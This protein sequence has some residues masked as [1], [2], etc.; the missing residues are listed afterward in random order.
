MSQGYGVRRVQA[1]PADSAPPPPGDPTGPPPCPP[2]G[3]GRGRHGGQR[4]R[5]DRPPRREGGRADHEAAA[6]EAKAEEPAAKDETKLLM[7]VLGREDSPVKVYG[8]IQN[9]YTG[10]TNG[11]AQE[12]PELRRQPELPGQ[13][14]DGQPVLPDLR[15]PARAE[16]R[17]QLRLP[18]RQPVRQRLAVQP[19]AGA[20]RH[21]FQLNHFAGYDPAQIYAE[22]HLP[23]LTKGGIDI[24]GGRFYTIL[25]YEV[26]PATGRPLLSVPYMFNYGQPFTHF[27]VLSTLHL[28]DRSTS[29]TAR[30][31]ARTAGST[32]TTSGTTS[33]ASPGPPRRARPT[34][35]SPTSGARTS[36]PRYLPGTP[37]DRPAR[38]HDVPSDSPAGGNL[39]YGANNRIL[40]TNVFSYKWT[41]KLTQ[42]IETDEAFENNIPGS[43]GR[44]QR[45]VQ[46]GTTD[47]SW[48]SFG[49][50][51]LYSPV[52][53]QADRR[54][55]VGSLPRQQR[56]PHRV[57]RQL[58]RADARPDLQAQA[59]ALDPARSPVRLGRS[60]ATPYNDG[61]RKSQ[62][63]LAVDVI[64]LF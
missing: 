61:T 55:A 41:D 17:D 20:V 19:H 28:T 51:F 23:L 16:R 62:F 2:R 32:R 11:A 1:T 4:D 36:I 30:S 29:T 50:W 64:L 33:A 38:Q 37:A 45:R 27:G 60:S 34:S 57:R 39:G 47:A 25:G 15:E 9:S 13:P 14:L 21:S 7:N 6:E 12:R 53:R 3:R 18:R 54:L 63:T 42:V 44:R 26:V 31:T 46:S 58:L 56:R 48:Y 24:K 35:P 8:W 10:N 59:L 22:V 43:V 49:N 40:F 5:P 52:Q